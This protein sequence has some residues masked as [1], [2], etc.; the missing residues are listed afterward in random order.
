MTS[1]SQRVEVMTSYSKKLVQALAYLIYSIGIY[2]CTC[3]DILKCPFNEVTMCVS[4]PVLVN[5][6]IIECNIN[7]DLCFQKCF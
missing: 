6:L 3:T 4:G 7:A 5:S 1:K 2:I